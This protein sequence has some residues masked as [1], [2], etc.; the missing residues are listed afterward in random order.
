MIRV[1]QDPGYERLKTGLIR[2]TGLAFYANRDELLAKLIGARLSHL[3]LRDCSSY[4]EFLADGE[5]GRSEKEVLFSHLTIGE[6]YFFRD[7]EQFAAIRHIILPEILERNRTT[8]E[9][10]IWSAGCANGAEPY[11]LA[12]L[13]TQADQTAN[14]RIRIYASDLNRDYLAQAAEGKFR[15]SAFR[16]TPVKVQNECFSKD[17]PLWTIH[18]RYR[19][20]VSFHRINLVQNESITAF[21]LGSHFDLILCRHVMIYFTAEVRRRLIG[22]FHRSLADDGWLVVGAS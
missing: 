6:S 21:A 12:I 14:W 8:K 20:L 3:N 11:S 2:S 13:L 9:I 16:V 7:A 18:E 5:N 15:A 17:G 19:Q 1:V 10:W 22:Q 4:E